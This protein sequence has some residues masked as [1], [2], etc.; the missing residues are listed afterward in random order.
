MLGVAQ[1]VDVKSTTPA[2]LARMIDEI[3]DPNS[4]ENERVKWVQ[5][6]MEYD[7]TAQQGVQ[8]WAEYFSKFGTGHLVPKA[9][10]LY[11]VS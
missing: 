6:V 9:H 7:E 3:S 4:P 1:I 11:F 8:Y 10:Y 2:E 5:S